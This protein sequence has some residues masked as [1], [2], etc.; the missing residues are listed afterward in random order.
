MLSTLLN[1]E[2]AWEHCYR[3][4]ADGRELRVLDEGGCV[5]VEGACPVPFFN[6]VLRATLRR[7]E[8]GA[9]VAELQ[10]LHGGRRAPLFWRLGPATT[11]RSAL[12]ACL[13]AAGFERAAD[14]VA[15]I[16]PS[17]ALTPTGAWREHLVSSSE[18]YADWFTV[19]AA[20]FG[21]P[22]ALRPFFTALAR[23]AGFSLPGYTNHVL[24]EGDHPI[25]CATTLLRGSHAGLFNFTVVPSRRRTGVARELLAVTFHWARRNGF[26]AVGQFSNPSA[27]PFYERAGARVL[28]RYSNWLWSAPC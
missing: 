10:A 20:G 18:G 9:R 24:Y 26:A 13:A 11:D 23:G 25:A 2:D 5:R 27:S 17:D 16:C 6:L 19:F 1:M 3:L 21:L 8:M 4:V 22:E 28:G 12:E 7:P 14:S 15:V